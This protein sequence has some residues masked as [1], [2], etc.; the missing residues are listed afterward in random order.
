MFE[1]KLIAIYFSFIYYSSN[2]M[3][4]NIVA[5]FLKI[6]KITVAY[7]HKV[8]DMTDSVNIFEISNKKVTKHYMRLILFFYQMLR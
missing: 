3:L 5:Y 4:L 2:F 1:L 6:S 8:I 7:L